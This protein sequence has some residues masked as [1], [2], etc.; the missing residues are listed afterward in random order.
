MVLTT[1]IFDNFVILSF[2]VIKNRN[3]NMRKIPYLDEG[4][5]MKVSLKLVDWNIPI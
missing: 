3:K 4:F 2:N 1:E 5:E